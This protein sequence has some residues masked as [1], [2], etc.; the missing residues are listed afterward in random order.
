M[1]ESCA[2]TNHHLSPHWMGLFQNPDHQH[3]NA[4][5]GLARYDELFWYNLRDTS[6]CL[7]AIRKMVVLMHATDN[8]Y[9]RIAVDMVW[10]LSARPRLKISEDDTKHR[11]QYEMQL[12]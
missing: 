6:K 3:R 4:T 7:L 5:V 8:S 12:G 1:T 2:V 11:F 10:I 9:D